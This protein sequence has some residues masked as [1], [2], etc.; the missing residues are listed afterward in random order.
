M[1]EYVD[2]KAER[3]ERLWEGMTP[4]GYN[5]EVPK[6]QAVHEATRPP[7]VPQEEANS[8]YIRTR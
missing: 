5:R 2:D 3:F 1:S 8:V 6:V 4:K 7:E